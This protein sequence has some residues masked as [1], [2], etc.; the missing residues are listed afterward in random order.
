[1]R[2]CRRWPTAWAELHARL[3]TGLVVEV[4]GELRSY[5]GALSLVERAE[6]QVGLRARRALAAAVEPHAVT[7]ASISHHGPAR[8]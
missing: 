7:L 3:L 2:R 1:M 5:E 6:R 4:D 8:G